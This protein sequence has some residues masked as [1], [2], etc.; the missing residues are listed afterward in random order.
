M[1]TVHRKVLD[2]KETLRI[3]LGETLTDI[4]DYQTQVRISMTP[5]QAEALINFI[6]G[7]LDSK[8]AGA[9]VMHL[10]IGGYKESAPSG[11]VEYVDSWDK[12]D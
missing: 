11:S 9:Q 4:L 3:R 7:T 12:G 5:N 1:E 10:W 2:G 8:P 6:R